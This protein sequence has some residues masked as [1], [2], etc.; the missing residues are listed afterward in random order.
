[1]H[2]SESGVRV[3]MDGEST[4][5]RDVPEVPPA[6][7]V[8]EPNPKGEEVKPHESIAAMVFDLAELARHVEAMTPEEAGRFYSSLALFGRLAD[9]FV[10]AGK[11][12]LIERLASG[13]PVNV[14]T[15]DGTFPLR[16]VP[17]RTTKCNNAVETFRAILE[18]E[19]PDALERVLTT[20]P[21]KPAACKAVLGEAWKNNFTVEEK[22]KLTPGSSSPVRRRVLSVGR[23][24]VDGPVID[25]EV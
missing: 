6:R 15:A 7:L 13:L 10:R 18:S 23:E 22:M 3:D 24:E 16:A 11:E 12:A 9:E 25:S 21:F 8:A 14:E 19:G 5:P 20:Q 4:P 1:M 17:D 2:L